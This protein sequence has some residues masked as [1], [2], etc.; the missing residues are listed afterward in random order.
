MSSLIS[1]LT[2]ILPLVIPALVGIV[3]S[4]VFMGRARK[5]ATLVIIASILM[6]LQSVFIVFTMTVLIDLAGDGSFSWEVYGLVVSS[7]HF[8]LGVSSTG[9][10]MAAAFV[11][12]SAAPTPTVAAA[13]PATLRQGPTRPHRGTAVLVM[14]LLGMLVFAPLGVVAWVLAVRDLRAMRN[15]EMDPEGRGQTTAGMVLGII[16]TVLMV[17]ALIGVGVLLYSLSHMSWSMH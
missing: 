11:G 10:L 14:G 6:L 1:S 16:A 17:L 7:V 12:R 13:T 4:I 5:A 8:V 9:L 15:G 3:L 2:A